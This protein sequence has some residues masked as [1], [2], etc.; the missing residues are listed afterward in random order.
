MLENRLMKHLRSILLLLICVTPVTGAELTITTLLEAVSKQPVLQS[1][2]LATE[3]TSIQLQQAH[4]EL[5]PKISAFAGY[6]NYNSPTNLRPMPPT[7]VNIS[8]GDSIPFSEKIERYGLKA[9]MPL[10]VKGIYTL[11]DKL[12]Q[13]QRVSRL[14]HKLNLV[15][16]QAEVVSVDASLSYLSQLNQAIVARIDSLQKTYQD[17]QMA[18]NNGR[19]AESELLKL[20]TSVNNLQKQQNDIKLERLS[21]VTQLR[22]LTGIT[23]DHAVTLTQRRP[24][25]D[26]QILRE[27]QQQAAVSAAKEEVQ[28]NWDQHY[29][30]VKLVG[31]LTENYGTAYNTDE[32]INRSYNFFGINI[33]I[34]LFDRSLS[35][36]IDLAQNQLHREKLHLTQLQIDLA[37]EADTLRQQLPILD[38]SQALAGKSLANSRK[39]LEISRV[40]YRNGRITTEDYI[41]HEAEVLDNEA[42]LHKTK[43]D[44]WQIICRQA[45]LYGDDLTGVVQ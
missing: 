35:T 31:A 30:T 38:Q 29:P 33:S 13:L 17:M 40:A 37:A 26:G 8:A 45:V 6:E 32:S 10:F 15:T 14:G 19:I 24:I 34:P 5:Y 9:E 39:V 23:V 12:K 42:A 36:S 2:Q 41:R 21:L 7:E 27:K 16:R 25:A 28:R 3:A 43:R 20:E 1:S 22:Q 4:S 44:R 18:V 11:A